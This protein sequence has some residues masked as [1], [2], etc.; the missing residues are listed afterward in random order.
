MKSVY[1]PSGNTGKDSRLSKRQV[2]DTSND[3]DSGHD[4]RKKRRQ[5]EKDLLK[6]REVELQD[7]NAKNKAAQE[8][9]DEYYE[10]KHAVQAIFVVVCAIKFSFYLISD[11]I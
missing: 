7:L 1:R 6:A 10:I 2:S 4:S 9:V 3:F 11:A 8:K 5:L